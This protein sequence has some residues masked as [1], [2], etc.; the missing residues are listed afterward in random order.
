[1]EKYVVTFMEDLAASNGRNSD[2]TDFIAEMRLRGKVEPLEKV[3]EA[4]KA[5]Y[6]S[7][8]DNITVQLNAIKAQELTPDEIVLLNCY[9]ECK[10]TTGDAYQKRIDSLEKYL[11]E[12]RVSSQKRAAQITELVSQLA[13]LS[14]G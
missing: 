9:R 13:E 2:P 12:V 4:V 7:V 10:T 6:Q 8:I 1:M 14:A 5:E 11:E 3:L